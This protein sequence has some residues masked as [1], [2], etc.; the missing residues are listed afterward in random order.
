MTLFL[1]IRIQLDNE[2]DKIRCLYITREKSTV[3]N[4]IH[5]P[6]LLLSTSLLKIKKLNE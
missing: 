1:Q 5:N 6:M 2:T 4:T 3:H